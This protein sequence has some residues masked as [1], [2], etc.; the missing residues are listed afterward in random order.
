ML[1][2]GVEVVESSDLTLIVDFMLPS[3][4][5]TVKFLN[6]GKWKKKGPIFRYILLLG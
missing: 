5:F 3:K 4:Y 1:M 6:K 2:K